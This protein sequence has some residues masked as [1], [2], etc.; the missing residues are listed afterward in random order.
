MSKEYDLEMS[1]TYLFGCDFFDEKFDP[2]GNEEHL[3][4]AEE[5][6]DSF[7][8]GDVFQSWNNYLHKNCYTPEDVINFCNLF[9][10]Y[11]GQDNII[12][13]PYEFIGYIYYMVDMDRYWDEAGEFLEGLSISIL[14]KSGDITITSDPYYQPWKDPKVLA[15]VK[16]YT[17]NNS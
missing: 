3:E 10:Y 16:K 13:D 6:M 5:I 9:S 1:T 12:P 15:V 8:W 2:E 14:E 17:E 7:L 4:C 11:G